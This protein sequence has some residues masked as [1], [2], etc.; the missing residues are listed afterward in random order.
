MADYK[1]LYHRA[2]T[3]IEAL[4]S[5]RTGMAQR[6]K[7]RE[8][9]QKITEDLAR[10]LCEMILANEPSEMVLGKPYSWASQPTAD[11]LRRAKEALKKQN[12]ERQIML[13]KAMKDAEE[14]RK[15]LEKLKSADNTA[16]QQSQDGEP[17]TPPATPASEDPTYVNGVVDPWD[18]APHIVRGTGPEDELSTAELALISNANVQMEKM[19]V[20]PHGAVIERNAANALQ[21]AQQRMENRATVQDIPLEKYDLKERAWRVLEIM[22][23]TGSAR[24]PQIRQLYVAKYKEENVTKTSISQALS[25]LKN[26][27]LAEKINI[28]SVRGGSYAYK[29]SPDGQAVFRK[30]YSKTPVSSEPDKAKINHDNLKHGYA[31]IYLAEDLEKR[32]EVTRAIWDTRRRHMRTKDNREVIPDLIVE[33]KSK[34]PLYI[35]VEMGS[36][37]QKS[38]ND[39]VGKWILCNRECNIVVPNREALAKVIAQVDRCIEAG[40]F[41]GEWKVRLSGHKDITLTPYSI[42]TD[43][44]WHHIFSSKTKKWIQNPALAEDADDAAPQEGEGDA[45]A[46]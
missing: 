41:S 20:T 9:T 3:Q 5:E 32:S 46:D 24:E 30:K 19:R 26:S 44:A 22:G 2:V 33:L 36:T 15:K 4:E 40:N 18:N 38:F 45:D 23:S 12:R 28:S 1:D 14:T 34:V 11:L 35:E 27:G 16:A 17:D 7:R 10:D 13:T 25:D 31:I 43:A 37:V 29:L 42:D 39:K 8:E 6:Q 21:I